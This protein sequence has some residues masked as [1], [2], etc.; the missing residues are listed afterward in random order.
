MVNLL[1]KS[2]IC[3]N[4]IPRVLKKVPL[5]DLLLTTLEVKEEK[6]YEVIRVM[7]ATI[8]QLEPKSI[9]DLEKLMK[10]HFFI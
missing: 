4:S 5:E 6:D 8:I 10:V 1:Q 9:K 2:I 3:E 7:R